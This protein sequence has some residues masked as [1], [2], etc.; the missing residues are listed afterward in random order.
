MYTINDYSEAN[1]RAILKRKQNRSKTNKWV[2][3]K[4]DSGEK[5]DQMDEWKRIELA[6]RSWK[7]KKKV[8]PLICIH[9]YSHTSIYTITIEA[10]FCSGF[11]LSQL[12]IQNREKN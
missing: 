6:N 2:K 8:G 10:E 3:F 1:K 11:F 5:K 9:W 4:I 12:D 7:K